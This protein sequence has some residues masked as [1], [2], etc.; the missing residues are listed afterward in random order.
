MNDIINTCHRLYLQQMLML[1]NILLDMIR[2]FQTSWNNMIELS[3]PYVLLAYECIGINYN[4]VPSG[5][6]HL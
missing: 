2:L 3:R 4:S 5:P 6:C 1:G